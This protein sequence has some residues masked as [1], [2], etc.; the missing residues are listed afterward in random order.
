MKIFLLL[1]SFQ[2]IAAEQSI[3]L[4]AT[5]WCPFTCSSMKNKGV[6][7]EFVTK[8]LAK[9]KIKLEVEFLPWARAV[10]NATNHKV[11]VS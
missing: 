11:D 8:I 7:T 1:L 6:V 10:S 5:D 2:I 3:K 9:H 4:A